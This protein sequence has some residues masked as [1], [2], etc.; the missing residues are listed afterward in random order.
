MPRPPIGPPTSPS[1]TTWSVRPPAREPPAPARPR[2]D[3]NAATAGM[4]PSPA[5]AASA[6]GPLAEH[7]HPVAFQ[8]GGREHD[9]LAG[10]LH[11]G[12]VARGPA[13]V[14]RAELQPGDVPLGVEQRGCLG[15]GQL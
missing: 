4:P 14:G 1:A 2:P 10:S 5:R 15:T 9:R 13:D 3:L 8:A 11:G 6:A 12:A 7:R